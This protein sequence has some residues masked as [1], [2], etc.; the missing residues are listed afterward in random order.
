M[1]GVLVTIIS[2]SILFVVVPAVLFLCFFF[3]ALFKAR[4]LLNQNGGPGAFRRKIL[5]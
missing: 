5:L 1:D 4:K 3:C 2:V